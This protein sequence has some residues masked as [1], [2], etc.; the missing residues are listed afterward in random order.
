MTT[1]TIEISDEYEEIISDLGY[2]PKEYF[3]MILD[4]L[5]KRYTVKVSGAVLQDN[6]GEITSEVNSTKAKNKV[7]KE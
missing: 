6:Q 3:E 1:L 4:D 2:T 7:K 5:G